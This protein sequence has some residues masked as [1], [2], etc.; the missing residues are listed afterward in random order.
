[1]QIYYYII[2]ILFVVDLERVT[3]NFAQSFGFTYHP[4]LLVCLVSAAGLVAAVLSEL[5]DELSS[6]K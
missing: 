1:M 4:T 3:K 2:Y 5:K 6:G